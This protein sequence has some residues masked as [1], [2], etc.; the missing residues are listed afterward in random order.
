MVESIQVKAI[1][2]VGETVARSDEEM[3]ASSREDLGAGDKRTGIS[4]D[5]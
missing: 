5:N 4:L 1:R 3:V 2:T